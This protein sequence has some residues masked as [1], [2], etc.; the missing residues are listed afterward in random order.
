MGKVA[1]VKRAKLKKR[2]II[3]SKIAAYIKGKI[4]LSGIMHPSRITTV[5]RKRNPRC[6][7][8]NQLPAPVELHHRLK[9]PRKMPLLKDYIAG[10]VPVSEM[11]PPGKMNE[12]PPKVKQLQLFQ[13]RNFFSPEWTNPSY[14][15]IKSKNISKF[16]HNAKPVCSSNSR[17][18]SD[19]KEPPE[20]CGEAGDT[21]EDTKDS[22]F[23]SGSK[24]SVKS[25]SQELTYSDKPSHS[26]LKEDNFTSSCSKH[27]CYSLTET[28][29]NQWN[30]NITLTAPKLS[31]VLSISTPLK[32]TSPSDKFTPVLSTSPPSKSKSSGLSITSIQHMLDEKER[33]IK[34][35]E[36]IENH[37]I[38]QIIHLRRSRDTY[39]RAFK[40]LRTLVKV[41]SERSYHLRKL[42]ID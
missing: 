26:P 20:P 22:V 4:N 29:S 40:D 31:P 1:H 7:M 17:K 39:K 36:S 27:S 33:I 2:R 21:V 37:L 42:D 14:S 41:L 35:H 5:D 19:F 32:S 6:E 24:S 9:K 12:I 38:R 25:I 13:M 16:E 34:A 28:I 18:P 23:N 8:I 15:L 30:Q 11:L 10:K 3:K